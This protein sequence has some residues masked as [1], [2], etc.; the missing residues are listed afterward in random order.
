MKKAALEPAEIAR[1][2]VEVASEKQAADI[3]LLDMRGLCD[4]TD[5]F[6]IFTGESRRQMQALMED[7]ETAL[8]AAGVPFHHQ[9]GNPEGGWILMD[10]GYLIVHAFSPE[11]RDIYRLEH[12]WF[13]AP[14]LLRIQ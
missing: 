2:V 13:R 6:V 4:F 7:V 10:Y 9:E 8:D 5:Y 14:V 1:L 12:L 11:E 3:V